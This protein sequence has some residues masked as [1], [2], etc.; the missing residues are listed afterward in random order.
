MTG[1]RHDVRRIVARYSTATSRATS[2]SSISAGSW[3]STTAYVAPCTNP[4]RSLVVSYRE[5]Q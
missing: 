2:I 4:R 1:I 3:A 5:T